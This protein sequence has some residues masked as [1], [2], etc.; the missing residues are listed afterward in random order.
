MPPLVF[1]D[2]ALTVLR[3]GFFAV[4][5]LLFVVCLVDWLV[6]T[7]RLDP[8]GRVARFMR[9]YVQPLIAPVERRV[10][11]AGGLPSSAPWW[12]LAAV[13]LLGIVVIS[14]L[15]FVRTEVGSV[16]LALNR[17]PAAIY[18]LLV[19]WVVEI[20]QIALIVR[21]V[22]SW[23]GARPGRW[24]VRWSYRLTEWMLR[25]LRRVIPMIGMIDVTPIVAWFVLTLL[26]AFFLRRA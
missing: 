5:A 24:Y 11:R 23:V 6:R 2:N 20:L 17:G 4:A 15:E 25:P 19:T 21:V 8:F 16:S 26:A 9:A 12:A 13:V 14:L 10:V 22:L 7:R 3:A 1:F 18:R